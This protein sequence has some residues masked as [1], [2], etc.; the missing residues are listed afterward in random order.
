[1][2][3]PIV[4]RLSFDTA[5]VDAFRQSAAKVSVP[6]IAPASKTFADL[7]PHNLIDAAAHGDVLTVLL[8]A[9]LFGAA[10]RRLP[11]PPRTLLST[12]SRAVADATLQCVHWVLWVTPFGVLALSLRS[13]LA[14]GSGAAG[15]LG[16]Y[17]AIVAGLLIAATLALYPLTAVAGR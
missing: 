7:L 5:T 3:T 15:L 13:T 9:V 11:E 16:I 2:T 6:A 10:V 4:H 17:L 14:I 1:I 12:F 8:L